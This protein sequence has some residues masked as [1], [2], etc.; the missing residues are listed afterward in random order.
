LDSRGKSPSR[1]YQEGEGIPAQQQKQEEEVRKS[2]CKNM[3]G[4][5]KRSKAPNGKDP[6][7]LQLQ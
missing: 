5:S 6:I 3:G 2:R 7:Q 1:R 4:R